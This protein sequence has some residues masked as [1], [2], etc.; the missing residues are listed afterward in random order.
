MHVGK[1]ETTEINA[2]H[3]HCNIIISIRGE[4]QHLAAHWG[5]HWFN[6]ITGV[7]T[8][9]ILLHYKNQ[10]A[11]LSTVWMGPWRHTGYIPLWFI[12]KKKD[13]QCWG[14]L[15]PSPIPSKHRGSPSHRN[16]S[17]SLHC[18]QHQ[19]S[20]FT[21]DYVCA[22]KKTSCT[23]RQSSA[24]LRIIEHKTTGMLATHKQKKSTEVKKSSGCKNCVLFK[25]ASKIPTWI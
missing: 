11:S 19:L 24:R 7:Y 4:E 16:Q 13:E 20:S 17:K 9:G 21:D 5:K 10:Q 3:F 25:R 23:V 8:E 1:E 15:R 14:E 22:E 18:C 12:L 6:L 2:F